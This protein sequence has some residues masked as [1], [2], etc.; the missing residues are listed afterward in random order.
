VG[1]AA[2]VT[3]NE[4]GQPVAHLLNTIGAAYSS[5]VTLD[6]LDATNNGDL[7]GRLTSLVAA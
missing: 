2:G 6:D 7:R 4:T 3:R 1:S 5:L